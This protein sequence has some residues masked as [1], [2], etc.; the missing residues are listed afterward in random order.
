MAAPQAA[1][2]QPGTPKC[3]MALHGFDGVMRTARIEATPRPEQGADQK[4]VEAYEANQQALHGA[5]L[6][7]VTRS[8]R[9]AL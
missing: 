3:A 4:L 7:T 1:R 5:T 8:L 9:M 6:M 2:S